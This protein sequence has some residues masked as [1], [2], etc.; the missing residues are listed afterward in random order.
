MDKK[1]SRHIRQRFRPILNVWKLYLGREKVRRAQNDD[2]RINVTVCKK[3]NQ[4]SS[5]FKERGREGYAR[6]LRREGLIEM[7]QVQFCRDVPVISKKKDL[8]VN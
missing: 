1:S 8:C 7:N 6:C 3:V 4:N 5:G 2:W